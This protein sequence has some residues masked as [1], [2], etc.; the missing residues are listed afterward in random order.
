MGVPNTQGKGRFGGRTPDETCNWK[1]QSNRPVLCCHLVTDTNVELRGLATAIP[2]FVE[3]L[4]SLLI[5]PLAATHM[6]YE[7][8]RTLSLYHTAHTVSTVR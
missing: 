8:V 3:L 7:F 2:P 1:L 5:T 6:T 4:W